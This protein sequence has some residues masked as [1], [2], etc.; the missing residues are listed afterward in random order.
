MAVVAMVGCPARADAAD[1]AAGHPAMLIH[2]VRGQYNGGVDPG[3]LAE[4]HASGI[5]VDY[6]DRHEDFTW[7]RIKDYNCPVI[8][9]CPGEQGAQTSTTGRL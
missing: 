9:M 5:E 6:S 1:Q 8:F 7:Q 3:F 2:A 4:L